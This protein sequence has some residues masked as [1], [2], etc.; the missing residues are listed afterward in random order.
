MHDRSLAQNRDHEIQ[1][2]FNAINA[3]ELRISSLERGLG[4]NEP[5]VGVLEDSGPA[6]VPVEAQL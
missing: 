4:I 1:I 5:D 6:S 3:L 2:L